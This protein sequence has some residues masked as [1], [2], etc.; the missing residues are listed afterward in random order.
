[1]SVQLLTKVD[2]A[3]RWQ[4]TK[5]T[6]DRLVARGA[7][8]KVTLGPRTIRFRLLDVE[9]AENRLRQKTIMEGLYGVNQ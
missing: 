2:L 9:A 7:V 5:R 1:M 4:V 3:E 8:S 6:I